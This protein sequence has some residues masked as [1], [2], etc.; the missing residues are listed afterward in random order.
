MSLVAAK[1]KEAYSPPNWDVVNRHIHDAQKAGI[2]A[3]T[4]DMARFAARYRAAKAFKGDAFEGYSQGVA[5]GY[6]SILRMFLA[7]SAME[8]LLNGLK[9]P[10]TKVGAGIDWTERWRLLRDTPSS[11]PY[12]QFIAGHVES[13][14]INLAY[15][16]FL[17]G[18]VCSLVLLA[19]GARHAFVHGYLTPSSGRLDGENTH[20]VCDQL[21]SAV[22]YAM[23]T[24]V[25]KMAR[26]VSTL[27]EPPSGEELLQLMQGKNAS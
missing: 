4:P 23:D 21:A 10:N 15:T 3:S 25:E 19:A 1:S 18:H 16:A 11:Q 22:L 6:D 5:K 17:N 12:L 2:I 13:K 8:S 26:A 14:P 27:Y 9:I 24:E 7:Y 20:Q